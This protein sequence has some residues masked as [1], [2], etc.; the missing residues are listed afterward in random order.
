MFWVDF[1]V[2]VVSM[3]LLRI[4]WPGWWRE[5]KGR[6]FIASLN[7][8][9]DRGRLLQS[10][11]PNQ[12]F[13]PGLELMKWVEDVKAWSTET[14]AFLATV[15]PRAAAAFTHVINAGQADRAIRQSE[16]RMMPISGYFGDVYQILQ[17]K[18]NNLQ[19]ITETVVIYF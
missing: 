5:R 18:L 6:K 9:L 16:G 3:F 11:V 12:A 2:L 15:S 17:V 19:K 1:S 4:S 13:N 7:P 14:E 10:S 8:Y